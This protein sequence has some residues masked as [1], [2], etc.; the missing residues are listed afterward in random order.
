MEVV[1]TTLQVIWTDRRIGWFLYNTPTTHTPTTHK[2]TTT[3]KT[4]FV[5]RGFNTYCRIIL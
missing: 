3:T 4:T 5:C 2:K 1:I